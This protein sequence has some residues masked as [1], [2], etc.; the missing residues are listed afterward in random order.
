MSPPRIGAGVVRMGDTIYVIG[1]DTATDRAVNT[2]TI[3]TP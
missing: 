3:T 2:A 1:G